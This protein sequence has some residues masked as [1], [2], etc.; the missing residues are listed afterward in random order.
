MHVDIFY[1][2]LFRTSVGFFSISQEVSCLSVENRDVYTG[3]NKYCSLE[4]LK[5]DII[6]SWEKISEYIPHK[7]AKSVIYMFQ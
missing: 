1:G 4:G 3:N 2:H 5:L 6:D 7:L